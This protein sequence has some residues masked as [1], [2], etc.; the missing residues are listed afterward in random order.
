LFAATWEIDFW[1]K[2]R[3]GIESDRASYLG[4]IAAVLFVPSFFVV[5][6]KFAERKGAK[7]AKSPDQPVKP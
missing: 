7:A 5:L 1:G 3:R 6:Q 2:Y 4:S